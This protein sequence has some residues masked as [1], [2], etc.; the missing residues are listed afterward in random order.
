M[1]TKKTS[2][3]AAKKPGSK[4]VDA[5]AAEQSVTVPNKNVGAACQAAVSFEG[6]TRVVAEAKAGSSGEFVVT[7]S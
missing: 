3:K 6:A 5:A 1:A 7:W 4:A 2:K